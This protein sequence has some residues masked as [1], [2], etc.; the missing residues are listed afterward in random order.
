MYLKE[1]SCFKNAVMRLALL[2]VASFLVMLCAQATVFA[3][4]TPWQITADSL[5]HYKQPES[6]FAEG[7]VVLNRPEESGPMPLTIK[8]DWVRYDVER[9][10]IKARG[11]VS[12][13]SE[14][15]DIVAESAILDLNTQAGTLSSATLFLADNKIYIKG[16]EIVKTGELTYVI[17]DA[18][19]SACRPDGKKRPPWAI[20]SSKSSLTV[21]GLA[22]LKN[23]TFHV[24]EVP[25]AYTP[26]M[27]FPAKTKRE[28][29]FLFP[30]ISQSS[31]NGFGFLPPFFINLSPSNDITIYPN[32]LE[33]RGVHSA[34]EYRYV[35]DEKSLGAFVFSYL[36]DRKEDEPG[37]EYKSDGYLRTTKNR[38]WFRGKA[39]HDFGNNLV[40]RLDIDYVSDRDYLQEFQTGMIGY[41]LADKQF[42]RSFNRGFQEES[43]T[44]RESSLQLTKS[45]PDMTLRGELLAVRDVADAGSTTSPIQTLPRIQFNGRKPIQ[46]TPLSLAWASEYVYFWRDEGV[47][48]QRLDLHPQLITS[49]PRG[50]FFE[51]KTTVGVRETLYQVEVHGDPTKHSWA[52][53]H[54]QNR[55]SWDLQ[56][57]V[58]TLFM[59]DFDLKIGSME[60]LEH[61]V[62]PNV[63]YNYVPSVDQSQLPSLRITPQNKITYELNN[64]FEIGGSSD[65]GGSYS[66][67]LGHFKVSQSYDIREDRRE[68]S[69][70]LDKQRVLSDVNFDLLAYPLEHLETKYTTSWNVYGE[71]ISKYELRTKY[72]S[73]RGD[74]LSLNYRYQRDSAHDL[75]GDFLAKLTNMVS[76]RGSLTEDFGNDRTV[77][78]SLGL[79]YKPYCW[80]MEVEASK[81]TDDKRIMVI[82]SLDGIGRAFRWSRDEQSS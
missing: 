74:N 51:G 76:L 68:L 75:K 46:E 49:L 28:T 22:V 12:M 32:Y 26:Y 42:L 62:R 52:Y 73:D 78:S 27:M 19:A 15:E 54:F 57:N 50:G 55:E 66:R 77:E 69:G 72:S 2:L 13:V 7:N 70:S 67:N 10:T 38:Y 9:G 21:D 40:A 17:E 60:W 65:D 45:W 30:E 56:T 79:I 11:N 71:G 14:D 58:A 3:Q 64:Y 35:S 44:G 20:R 23:A 36:D 6:I 37:D 1:I 59:R 4:P 31:R 16:S 8:A 41:D 61:T 53:D 47:G 34:I 18:W 81:T 63:I 24:K 48:E 25:I 29:G 5:I 39:D 80:M 43:I 82:F 33:K